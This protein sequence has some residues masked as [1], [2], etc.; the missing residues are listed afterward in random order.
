MSW[1]RLTLFIITSIIHFPNTDSPVTSV[2]TVTSPVTMA[3]NPILVAVP[4]EVNLT[5]MVAPVT[6]PGM[7]PQETHEGHQEL[8]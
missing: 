4:S 1:W 5:V 7:E 8:Q 3:K 2:V 6:G